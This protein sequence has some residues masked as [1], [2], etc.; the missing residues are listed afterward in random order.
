VS[1]RRGLPPFQRDLF[2]LVLGGGWGT[3][4]V[5]TAGPWPLMLISAATMLGPGFLRLWL[6]GPGTGLSPGS[7]EPEP[8]EPPRSLSAG[9]STVVSEAEAT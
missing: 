4:T 2:F 6:S 7:P 8:P 1:K 3:W 5:I 9:S